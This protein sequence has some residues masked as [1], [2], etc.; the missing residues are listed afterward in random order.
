M[1]H[2]F[3]LSF[4]GNLFT[5]DGVEEGS[6]LSLL[7]FIISAIALGV[8]LASGLFTFWQ[9][10]SSHLF[11]SLLAHEALDPSSAQPLSSLGYHGKK[12]LKVLLYLLSNPSCMLYKFI[13]SNVR[14]EHIKTMIE[15]EEE[16]TK[17]TRKM[18][19]RRFT[20]DENTPFYIL[21]EKV[22]YVKEKGGTFKFDDVMSFVYVTL[23]C[24]VVWFALLS[25]LDPIVNFL[26]G[27]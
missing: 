23:L 21:P 25:F 5:V 4:F 7:P 3:L 22:A 19:P 12:S 6:M 20:I 15:V 2:P 8:I 26:W 16:T 27:V 10:I 9:G 17:T 1:Q 11:G 14:D 24:L 18:A 13:S